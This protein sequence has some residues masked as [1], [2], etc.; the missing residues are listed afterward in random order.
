MDKSNHEEFL[1]QPLQTNIK[2]FK[3]AVI[4]LTGKNGIFNVTNSNNNFYFAKS[5]TDKDGFVQIT[6]STSA[7]E[8]ENF[9][10]EMNRIF[11]REGSFL[12]A[13]YAFTIQPIFSTLGPIIEISRHEALFRMYTDSFRVYC[14]QRI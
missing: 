13:N 2:H 11:I 3:L 1:S 6:V 7:Y 12:E 9:N 10:I 8:I 5:I 4:L 14:K